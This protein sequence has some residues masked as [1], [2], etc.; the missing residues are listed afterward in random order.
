MLLAK[1]RGL[2]SITDVKLPGSPE[3][4]RDHLCLKRTSSAKESEER[5]VARDEL[6]WCVKISCTSIVYNNCD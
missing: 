3:W 1:L 2:R 6:S 4:I 5:A